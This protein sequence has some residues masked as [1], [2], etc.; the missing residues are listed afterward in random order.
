VDINAIPSGTD[1][2]IDANVVIYFLTNASPD[3]VN[4]FDRIAQEDLFGYLTTTI[5]A[6][7]LHRRMMMEAQ[8]KGLVTSGKA[9]AKLKAQPSLIPQLT[10]YITEVTKFLRLPLDVFEV[11]LVDIAVSHALRTSHGLFVN[12]SLN[13]A[14]AQGYGISDIVTNDTDFNRVPNIVVWNPTDI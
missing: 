7:V 1:C 4:F 13:L 10:D 8:A 5:V 14:C 9:L 12:D 6:E 11:N 3:C 2:L